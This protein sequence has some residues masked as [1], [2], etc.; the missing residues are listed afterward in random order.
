MMQP[1][2]KARKG[3]RALR[4]GVACCVI[5]GL[6]AYV[7]R[8]VVLSRG[9]QS[10]ASDEP[11]PIFSVRQAQQQHAVRL[12]SEVA[13]VAGKVTFDF[14]LANSTGRNADIA[15]VG[16]T[17]GCLSL[18]INGAPARAGD[19]VSVSPNSGAILKLTS[20]AGVSHERRGGGNYAAELELRSPPS[21]EQKMRLQGT[22]DILPDLQFIPEVVPVDLSSLSDRSRKARVRLRRVA[23][24]ASEAALVPRITVEGAGCTVEQL[25][26]T[27]STSAVPS[28]LFSHEWECT[29]DLDPK[30]L[31]DPSTAPIRPVTATG[32]NGDK[33]VSAR[34]TIRFRHATG[35]E[36][37]RRLVVVP[38]EQGRTVEKRLM[39]VAR[40]G[41]EFVVNRITCDVPDVECSV[42]SAMP[43]ATHWL[44]VHCRGRHDSQHGLIRV[45]TDH[46]QSKVVAM[47]LE[48]VKDHS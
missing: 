20:A 46:P 19:V 16:F 15:V 36:A 33:D 37:P 12:A 25:S 14:D 28:G 2:T 26:A 32:R 41:R 30:A 3:K 47:E 5:L 1:L 44:K 31:I 17:C 4:W 48:V 45:E 38:A 13:D 42:E 39:I 24:T 29:I 43:S 10:T 21:P 8:F 18:S 27:E 9:T 40:D 6:N 11:D 22:V 23:R 35:I 7:L 34:A